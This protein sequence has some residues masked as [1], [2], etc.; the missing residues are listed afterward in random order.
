MKVK[1]IRT[2][3]FLV[4]LLAAATSITHAN[5]ITGALPLAGI[6]TSENGP[7][8][9]LSTFLT[10]TQTLTS[11]P[12]L[13]DFSVV[14]LFTDYGLFSLDLPTIATGGGFSISNP[15]YG[16]FVAGSGSIDFQS[17]DF[18]DVDLF[19][20]YTPGPGMPGVTAGPMEVDLSFTQN[21]KSVSSSMTL[22]NSVPE[23]STLLLLGSATF[24]MATRLR[25]KR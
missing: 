14:P 17:E 12:G 24:G 6:D 3:L 21:G 4:S 7:N 1:R 20:T 23:P 9:L 5:Q 22:V 11:G 25:R 15:T 19:G 8:L 2:L 16:S 10:D 13:G 18:L